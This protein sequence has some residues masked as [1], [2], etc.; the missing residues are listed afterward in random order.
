M[1][2]T[3]EYP[4]THLCLRLVFGRRARFVV[5][6]FHPLFELRNAESKRSGKT[7]QPCAKQKQHDHEQDD[8]GGWTEAKHGRT[9][10]G[11]KV[12]GCLGNVPWAPCLIVA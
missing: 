2:Q 12:R 11:L 5:D 6:S 4:V 9:R 10:G 7:R 8:Q 1:L 3:S